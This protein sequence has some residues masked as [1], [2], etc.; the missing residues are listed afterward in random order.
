MGVAELGVAHSLSVCFKQSV[1][2]NE[3]LGFLDCRGHVE[4]V[5]DVISSGFQLQTHNQ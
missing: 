4:Y 5:V 2:L 1:L 3:L